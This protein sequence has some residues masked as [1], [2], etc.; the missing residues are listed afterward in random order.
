MV[1][2]IIGVVLAI[3]YFSYN[4]LIAK[5]MSAKRMKQEFIDNQCSVGKILVNIFY[6]PAWLLKGLKAVVIAAIA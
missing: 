4:V 6:A 1:W 3:I 5:L 2:S